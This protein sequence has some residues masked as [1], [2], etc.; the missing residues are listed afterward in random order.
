MC[1]FSDL[2][3]DEY[4]WPSLSR[5]RPVRWQP[6]LRVTSFHTDGDAGKPLISSSSNTG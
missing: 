6:I 4:Q 3:A 5:T 1:T 2:D